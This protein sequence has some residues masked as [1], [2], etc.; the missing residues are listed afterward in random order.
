VTAGS[1][2][3]GQCWQERW[4]NPA[5]TILLILL[6]LQVFVGEPLSRAHSPAACVFALAWLLLMISV[7][8]LAA[9]H[10]LTIAV[11][12][13]ASILA[14]IANILQVH[15]ASTLSSAVRSIV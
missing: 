15:D 11:L 10:R 13:T 5:L 2:G 9:R 7:V 14:L 1:I 12:L 6:S 8:L 4:R 3:D